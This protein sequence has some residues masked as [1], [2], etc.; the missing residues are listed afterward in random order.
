MTEPYT[1]VVIYHAGC[2]DGVA[3]AFLF[4]LRP[5]GAALIRF[6]PAHERDFFVDG[7]MPPLE[8]KTVYIVDYSYSRAALT[9]I[10]SIAHRV[11]VYDHHKSAAEV[12]AEGRN[13]EQIA[14]VKCVFDM[15]RCGAEITCDELGVPRPWWMI[16]IRDRDLWEWK[17]NDSR[18]FSEALSAAGITFETFAALHTMDRAAREQFIEGGRDRIGIQS[19]VVAALCDAAQ[20]V[21]FDKYTVY[22]LNSPRYQSDCGNVLSS[23]LEADFAI[24]YYYDLMRGEWKISLRGR[25]DIDLSAVAVAYGGGGHPG[26][27]GFTWRGDLRDLFTTWGHSDNIYHDG[28][29]GIEVY[30]GGM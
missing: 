17:H 30:R 14:G 1:T 19:K 8:G 22:A 28:A 10:G 16:H 6:H 4:T 29:S 24:V 5:Q 15:D 13:N 2:P 3:A 23:R 21:Q 7:D 27:A 20:L 25:R 12:L 18:A 26:A 11:F 9:H